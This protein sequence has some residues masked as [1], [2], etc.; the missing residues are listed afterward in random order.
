M[1]HCIIDIY[2]DIS[3]KKEIEIIHIL[4]AEN[5]TLKYDEFD[6]CNIEIRTFHYLHISLYLYFQ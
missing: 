1:R 4:I 3:L 2:V 6:R 5:V